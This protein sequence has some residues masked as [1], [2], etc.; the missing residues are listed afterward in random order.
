MN[1]VVFVFTALCVLFFSSFAVLAQPDN[2]HSS[3]LNI[4]QNNTVLNNGQHI[5][6]ILQ[7]QQQALDAKTK[8]TSKT[9][10]AQ[11]RIVAFSDYDF[12]LPDTNF[13]QLGKTDSASFTYIN[14]QRGSKFNLNTMVYD[15]PA[16]FYDVSYPDHSLFTGLHSTYTGPYYQP[17][18]LCDSARFWSSTAHDP[19]G[20][21]KYIYAF[22]DSIY[23]VYDSNANIIVHYEQSS[24][25]FTGIGYE[26]LNTY[27]AYSRNTNSFSL[28]WTPSLTSLDTANSM[29]H[30][31]NLSSKLAIDSLNTFA[32]GVWT[33]AEKWGYHYDVYGNLIH[34]MYFVDSSGVW[35][36]RE[37]YII[38][39]NGDNYLVTDSDMV[40]QGGAW[41][42][43]NYNTY[44]YSSGVG[45]YT[46]YTS[47]NFVDG[48]FNSKAV[49]TK[50]VCSAGANIGLPD[51]MYTSNYDVN[52]GVAPSYL[53]SSA[54]SVFSYDSYQN[55]A[56][57]SKYNY[58]ITSPSSGAGAY[59]A[60]PDGFTYYY[61]QQ[62]ALADVKNVA[63]AAENIKVYPNPA[64]SQ[65][66]IDRPDAVIGSRTT[67]TLLNM[68]GQVIQTETLPWAKQSETMSLSGIAPGIYF[69][70][71]QDAKGKTLSTNKILRQ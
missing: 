36:M 53:V 21:H 42:L 63:A 47:T 30:E 38:G 13:Y 6:A 29:I 54:M 27:D 46:S 68:S 45:Y 56:V 23:D 66:T 28:K 17:G 11:E 4:S 71:V 14:G 62:Y 57:V 52:T 49:Y 3:Y 61:Y 55:P 40:Y 70:L 35:V 59:D 20:K 18:I 44:G 1:K 8:G 19:T 10:G 7:L 9:T 37:Q 41:V 51:T 15:A 12:Y 5:N 22:A 58:K 43:V 24:P 50:H 32:S 64:S 39:Y 48:A 16:D 65:V 60:A 34:A 25:S 69:L 2:A 26:Y 31:Y 33:P 67:L